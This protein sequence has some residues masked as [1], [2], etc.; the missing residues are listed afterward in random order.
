MDKP[1][2]SQLHSFAKMPPDCMCSL[3]HRD[4]PGLR[5]EPPGIVDSNDSNPKLLCLFPKTNDGSPILRYKI[6]IV[7]RLHNDERL[8]H[9]HNHIESCI[10][11]MKGYI[12]L[13]M[14][15]N[16]A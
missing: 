9:N 3:S 7:G 2:A 5:S 13:D 15:K 1:K 4:H 14:F 10:I 8:H 11:I 6:R 16:G 12:I